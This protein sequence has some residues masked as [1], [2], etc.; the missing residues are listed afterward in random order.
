MQCRPDGDGRHQEAGRDADKELE[1][2]KVDAEDHDALAILRKASMRSGV[3][4][5][6][7]DEAREGL[8]QGER[9]SPGSDADGAG[10]WTAG[11]LENCLWRSLMTA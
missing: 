4:S 3:K 7:P 11:V 5:F 6:E 10:T 9:T 8:W 2:F 1:V